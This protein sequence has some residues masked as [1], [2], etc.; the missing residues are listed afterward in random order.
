MADQSIIAAA[1]QMDARL[2]DVAGNLAREAFSRGARWV[3][4]PEFFTSPV[5]YHYALRHVA[6]PPDGRATQ[7]M[8]SLAREF[9]GYVG[10]SFISAVD[11]DAVNRYVLA[12]PDGVLG[13]HDKDQPTMWENAYYCGGN[14]DGV[15]ETPV[16]AVGAAVCWELVRARTVARLAGRVKLVVGG[17]CWWTLPEWDWS[18]LLSAPF[19]LQNRE[20]MRL[21][22]G[23]FAKLV[24]APM[25][26]A[27]HCSSFTCDTPYFPFLPYR[28]RYLGDAQIVAADGT[29]LAR[30]PLEEGEGVIGA[31][32]TIGTREP[33]AM[34]DGFWLPGVRFWMKAAWAVQ[35]PHGARQYQKVKR[36][37]AF[38]WQHDGWREPGADE[39]GS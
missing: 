15:I 18:H 39:S 34:P 2:G 33:E 31:G 24:G 5:G 6:L 23:R 28:S 37:G 7:M 12:G 16:G 14:D 11:G 26:H 3:M 17:S 38:N 22:P 10:G 25:I 32:G 1:V 35:N 30:R 9:N 8:C 29:M 20:T 36:A 13:V 19:A 4:L 21:V 27:S